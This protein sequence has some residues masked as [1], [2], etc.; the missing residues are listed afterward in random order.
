MEE[1][2]TLEQPTTA[3]SSKDLSTLNIHSLPASR[4][5]LGAWRRSSDQCLQGPPTT[6]R[7]TLP[8]TYATSLSLG[9]TRK[10]HRERTK[11][12]KKKQIDAMNT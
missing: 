6:Y 1:N 10:K 4:F 5:E 12:E 7:T 2:W 3:E 9:L 8:T 11:N